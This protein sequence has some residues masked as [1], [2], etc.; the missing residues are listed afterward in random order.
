MTQ[1]NIGR[2]QMMTLVKKQQ[3]AGAYG[4]GV[5]FVV[6]ML[7]IAIGVPNPTAFQYTVFRIVLALTAAGVASMIPGFINVQVG[8]WVRAGGAIAVFVVVYFF[9]PANLV[10]LPPDRHESVGIA[11]A[12]L[13]EALSLKEAVMMV[14]RS[15]G[16]TIEFTG[17]CNEAIL[18]SEVQPGLVRG[19][20][21]IELIENLPSRRK[22]SSVKLD[23]KVTKLEERGKYSVAC[24]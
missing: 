7:S 16:Y 17:N 18:K 23:L 2:S 11:T 12:N 15:D 20:S 21:T 8:N 1:L 13:P 22:D 4:F 19:K 10:A 9:S 3:R 6:V 14:A 24:N 5:L